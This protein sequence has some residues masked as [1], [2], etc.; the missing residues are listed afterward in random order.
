MDD[1]PLEDEPHAQR[2][3]Q[4]DSGHAIVALPHAIITEP[5]E[6][7]DLCRLKPPRF[8]KPSTASG[9]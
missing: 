2:Q 3:T 8:P 1:R 7:H 5:R 4:R 6:K 9:S